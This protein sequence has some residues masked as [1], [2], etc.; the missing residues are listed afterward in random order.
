MQAAAWPSPAGHVEQV[1][2]PPVSSTALKVLPSVQ[3]LQVVS[4]VAVQAAA[5]P[6]PAG[7]V[8]QVAQQLLSSGGLLLL[9]A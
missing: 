1:V 2:Q 3:A 6:S 5:W 8:E 4:C 9:F 7:H